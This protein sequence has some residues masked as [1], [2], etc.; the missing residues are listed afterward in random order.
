MFFEMVRALM[1]GNLLSKN[2]AGAINLGNA[3]TLV[4]DVGNM[5]VGKSANVS[6]STGSSFDG[7][8]H[9]E[10]KLFLVFNS[11]ICRVKDILYSNPL[12][13]GSVQTSDPLQEGNI[14]DDVGKD[15]IPS[16][17]ED[18]KKDVVETSQRTF[19][20]YLEGS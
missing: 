12:S 9:E 1:G 19:L 17:V 4:G 5:V 20:H 11:R 15:V 2:L 3:R 13:K 10:G 8:E 16:H 18:H 6:G 14:L 7:L